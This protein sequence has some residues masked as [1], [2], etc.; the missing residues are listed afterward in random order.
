MHTRTSSPL[1]AAM[2]LLL[3]SCGPATSGARTG[4]APADFT[5]EDI[6]GDR[7]HLSDYLGH[8]VIL[9]NFWATWC[10][11]C[12]GELT[13][14]QRI[15]EEYEDSGFVV[16]AVSMDGPESIAAVAPFARRHGLSFPVLLDEETAVVGMLNPKRAAPYSVLIGRDGTI[17]SANEGFSAGDEVALEAM[18]RRQLSGSVHER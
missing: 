1:I 13:H 16:L 9:I 5:L 18:I 14:L 17:M 2:A 6:D 10:G 15:Y 11:P 12:A 7:V 8:E 3:A 4:G